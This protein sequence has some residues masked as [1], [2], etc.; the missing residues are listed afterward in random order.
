M[1]VMPDRLKHCDL[2]AFLAMMIVPAHDAPF[3]ARDRSDIR[4]SLHVWI[5]QPFAMSGIARA[6]ES[7]PDVD[8]TGALIVLDRHGSKDLERERQKGHADEAD[9]DF[10]HSHALAQAA[11]FLP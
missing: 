7:V 11:G 2:G 9:R 5:V 1:S 3:A 4:H 10:Q 8:V 6:D